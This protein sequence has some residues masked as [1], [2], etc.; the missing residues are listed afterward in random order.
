MKDWRMRSRFVH[1]SFTAFVCTHQMISMNFLANVFVGFWFIWTPATSPRAVTTTL[2]DGRQN[3]R[4]S[5]SPKAWAESEAGVEAPRHCPG[6][7]HPQGQPQVR[8]CGELPPLPVL[9]ELQSFDLEENCRNSSFTAPDGLHCI[10]VF[11]FQ[12]IL[13]YSSIKRHFWAIWTIL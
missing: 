12:Q 2:W 1:L 13:F 9:R 6:M 5:S 8:S 10:S 3:P 4:H 11:S 7:E